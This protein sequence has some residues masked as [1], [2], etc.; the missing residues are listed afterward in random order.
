VRNADGRSHV[1]VATVGQVEVLDKQSIKTAA[2]LEPR[3]NVMLPST[4]A[5]GRAQLATQVT[6]STFKA[7]S[8]EFFDENDGERG[9]SYTARDALPK[10]TCKMLVRH[11]R[12]RW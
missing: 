12:H 5:A 3:V 7:V 4:I 9:I 8:L 10:K 6:R 11:G 1:D 2:C